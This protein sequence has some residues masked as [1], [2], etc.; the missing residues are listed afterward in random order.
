MSERPRFIQR[1][2]ERREHHRT[3]HPVF[4]VAWGAAGF[5]VLVAGVIML[6]TPGPAFVLIPVGLAMLALEFEWAERLLEKALDQAEKA[7]ARAENATRAQRVLG[8]LATVAVIAACVAA[9]ML[10]NV[11]VLPDS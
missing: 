1:L 2:L 9:V 7:K 10:V 4:R 3:R 11:P 8:V 6:V 5:V